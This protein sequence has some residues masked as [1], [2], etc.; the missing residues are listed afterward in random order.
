MQPSSDKFNKLVDAEFSF[1]SFFNPRTGEYL[2]TGILDEDEKDTGIDAFMSSFPHLLDVGIMG[3][4]SHGLSG[5]CSAAGTHCY[6]SGASIQQENMTLEDFKTI[7]D[8]SRGQVFQF[9]L[10]GRGDPDQHED[11]EEILSYCRENGIVPN[12]TTSGYLLDESKAALIGKY[13][14]AAAVSWYRNDYTFRAIDLLSDT[15]IHVN[16]HF[17]L[18]RRTLEEAIKLIEDRQI[19]QKINRI[20]FLLYKPVGQA[21][22]EDI[23]PYDERTRYFFSLIDTEYGLAKIGFDSCCVPGVLNSTH[24]VDP[25][26][27]DACEAGRFSAYVTPD[28]QFLPCSFDQSQ[29]WAVSLRTHSLK[30]AWSSDA[31]E[32]FRA[33]LRIAC[34]DCDKRA[35]CMGGCPIKP[36]ITLCPDVNQK[37]EVTVH[38]EIQN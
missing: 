32:A 25:S 12:M 11:F 5:R 21:T 9:A 14:G 8:Q 35:L 4:C 22:D 15:G 29:Q 28:M 19:H 18:S 6:Q 17:V 2:R 31:F 20:V 36:A 30:Q 24:I 33:H 1:N 16:L 7:V 10:G 3:H 27:Y 26:C 38:D 34:P 23:L 37:K 13:C